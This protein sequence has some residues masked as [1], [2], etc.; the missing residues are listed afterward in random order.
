MPT[1]R[2]QLHAFDVR[3][4]L[5]FAS[6]TLGGTAAVMAQVQGTP[7]SK[8]VFTIFNCSLTID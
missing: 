2:R 5:L 4:V 8:N 1:S 3:S 6:L 7:S